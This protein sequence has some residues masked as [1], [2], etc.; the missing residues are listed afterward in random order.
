MLMKNLSS[1]LFG[2]VTVLVLFVVAPCFGASSSD[3]ELSADDWQFNLAPFYLWAINIDG[4]LSKGANKKPGNAPVTAPLKVSFDDVFDS[5]ESAFIVHF[6]GMHKSNFGFLVD[7]DYLNIGNGSTNNQG[8]GLGV[9]LE[10]TLAELAG[11]YRA[12]RDDHTFDT[13][14]GVRGYSLST[15]ISML[16]GPTL[17]DETQDWFDPIIGVRW[18]W[19]FAEDWSLV[20]RGDIGGFGIGSDFAWQT[21]GLVEWQPFENASFLAGYRALDIDYEDGSGTDFFKFDATAH[22]PLLGVNFKW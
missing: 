7:V 17:V 14:F 15:E 18:T 2:P 20:A 11:L 4:N 3:K 1:R 10:V 6:E 9:D 13:V 5:L 22:G 19:Q 16:S 8:V 12:K 21:I